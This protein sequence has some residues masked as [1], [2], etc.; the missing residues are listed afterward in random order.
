MSA[1]IRGLTNR[2]LLLTEWQ[3]MLVCWRALTRIY[4]LPTF[5]SEPN[6]FITPILADLFDILLVAGCTAS[7]SYIISELSSILEI[8]I[9]STV[10]LA[11][12]LNQMINGVISG[13]FGVFVVRP[14]ERFHEE[15]MVN[16]DGSGDE[17]HGMRGEIG[18]AKVVL[19]TGELGLTSR[20]QLGTGRRP[21]CPGRGWFWSRFQRL[22][23]T[24]GR[25]EGTPF[26]LVRPR[27]EVPCLLLSSLVPTV[28]FRCVTEVSVSSFAGVPIQVS[29]RPRFSRFTESSV[30]PFDS[31]WWPATRNLGFVGT[32]RSLGGPCP[33]SPYN[34]ARGG[35]GLQ[36][37]TMT[38]KIWALLPM[39]L[40]VRIDEGADLT[41]GRYYHDTPRLVHLPCSH[42]FLVSDPKLSLAHIPPAFGAVHWH[43][44]VVLFLPAFHHLRL[45]CPRSRSRAI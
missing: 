23:I 11:R 5:V 36:D 27:G 21:R 28:A 12:C 35:R 20:V 24:S 10:S 40:P 16:L 6:S 17:V 43:C 8:K 2:N 32:P 18:R 33:V 37:S 26:V 44:L 4:A 45:Y 13:D 30:P 1:D 42:A 7:Q 34:T 25:F 3:A 19:C 9:L 14:G 41:R 29:P 39:K 15:T 38:Y 31:C 22:R